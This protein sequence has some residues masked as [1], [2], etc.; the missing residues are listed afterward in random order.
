VWVISLMECLTSKIL[1]CSL[2]THAG[3][4][5]LE[6]IVIMALLVHVI[7][8]GEPFSNGRTIYAKILMCLWNSYLA[9]LE[10]NACFKFGF[11]I[12]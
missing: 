12:E 6:Y 1:Y 9:A 4:Y 5:V 11:G 8:Y 2:L 7:S 10:W 3:F